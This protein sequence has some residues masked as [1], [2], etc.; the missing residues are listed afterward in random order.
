MPCMGLFDLRMSL[1][2]KIS[3]DRLELLF[4]MSFSF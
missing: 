1:V 3:D 4:D 2:G